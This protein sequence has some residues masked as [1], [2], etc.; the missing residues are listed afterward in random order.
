MT[1]LQIK[2]QKYRNKSRMYRHILENKS[3]YETGAIATDFGFVS[4]YRDEKSYSISFIWNCKE[5]EHS[6]V[7]PISG[8]TLVRRAS[9]L[10]KKIV[11]LEN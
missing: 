11:E 6:E 7:E 4:A 1:N 8:A 9:K 2:R 10:A 3:W 5:Y